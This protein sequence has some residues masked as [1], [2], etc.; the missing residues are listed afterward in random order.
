MAKRL[1]W[2]RLLES[3]AGLPFMGGLA[4]GP[5]AAAQPKT[6]VRPGDPAWP[7]DA[8]WDELN[9]KVE[10]RLVKVRSPLSACV[11]APFDA[12][13]AEVFKELKNPYYLGDEV[14]LPSRSAGSAPG[15]RARA[16]MRSPPGRRGRRRGG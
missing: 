1:S 10:G 14:G 8:A 12:A 9:R 5:L 2:R 16:S 15:R 4:P 6:R 3:L 13:C 7:S 11:G